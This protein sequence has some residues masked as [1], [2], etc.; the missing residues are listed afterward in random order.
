MVKKITMHN[1]I[2]GNTKIPFDIKRSSR[3]K[4]VG[5]KVEHSKAVTVIAP[6]K[7]PVKELKDKTSAAWDEIADR[8]GLSVKRFDGGLEIMAK[9]RDKGDA[10][11][12]ILDGSAPD[13]I[14]AYLGDDL[15]DE[16]AFKALRPEDLGILVNESLRPTAAHIWIRPP[17]ELIDFLNSWIE[18]SGVTQ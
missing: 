1:I 16:D 15:T 8:H 13:S 12:D 5:I 2:F 17:V 10:V 9:G 3:R 6:A 14:A 4:T 7:V 18:A 11:R